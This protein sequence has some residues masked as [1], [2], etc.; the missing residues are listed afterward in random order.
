VKLVEYLVKDRPDEHWEQFLETDGSIKWSAI[1]VAGQSQG[2]GHAALIGIKH[3]VA[4]VICMG[5]PKDNSLALDGPAAWLREESS[6]PKGR[7]FS[8]NHQQDHQGCSPAQ[9]MENLRALKLDAFGKPVDVDHT[10]AP[11]EGSRILTTNYPG[12]KIPSGE[13]HTSVINPHNE[14][15]FGNVWIYMLT[16]PVP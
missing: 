3:Q 12:G 16:A 6:T 2:G 11:Y 8:F 10:S 13:A 5:A 7:F 9:Q 14:A 1:A 15:V 4:R